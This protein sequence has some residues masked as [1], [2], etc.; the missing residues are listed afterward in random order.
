MPTIQNNITVE[1]GDATNANE[2]NTNNN[3]I[4]SATAILDQENTNNEWCSRHHVYYPT[5]SLTDQ[6]VFNSNFLMDQGTT[7]QVVNWNNYQVI[8]LGTP[9]RH[10]AIL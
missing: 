4:A 3:N 8:D 9:F 1:P 6:R 7:A 10:S 5:V 2:I